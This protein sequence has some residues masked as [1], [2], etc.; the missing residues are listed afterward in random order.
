MQV[1][2]GKPRFLFLPQQH[3]LIFVSFSIA[4]VAAV[5]LPHSMSFSSLSP[6]AFSHWPCHWPCFI[7]NSQQFSGTQKLKMSSAQYFQIQCDPSGS[8]L[9]KQLT[10]WDSPSHGAV[11][12]LSQCSLDCLVP[13]HPFHHSMSL[14]CKGL[15]PPEVGVGTRALIPALLAASPYFPV[16][17]RKSGTWKDHL[18]PC[19]L[20]HYHRLSLMEEDEEEELGLLD[21]S[22]EEWQVGDKVWSQQS[23]FPKVE[24]WGACS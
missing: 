6:F 19:T 12:H 18:K 20:C 24:A 2:L 17:T 23:L 3:T 5:S 7:L 10:R 8:G 21:G 4:F 14:Q 16:P 9:G 11:T 15:L 22:Y 1:R 13:R